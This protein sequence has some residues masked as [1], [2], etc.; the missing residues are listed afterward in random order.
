MTFPHTTSRRSPLCI[1]DLLVF[2]AI[3]ALPLAGARP[4]S[5]A[6]GFAAVMLALGL[7]LWW[8]P[9]LGGRGSWADLFIL[10]AFMALSLFYLFLAMVAFLCDPGAAVSV[11]GAQLIALVYVSF[12]S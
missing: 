7:L 12:R 3:S 1:V 6:G 5:G 10:P 2:I 11:I 9:R 8:L 4:P